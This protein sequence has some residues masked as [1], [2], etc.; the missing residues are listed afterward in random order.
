MKQFLQCSRRQ[1]E[2]VCICCCGFESRV[3]CGMSDIIQCS[4][5]GGV[6]TA[7][8]LVA[9]VTVASVEVCQAVPTHRGPVLCVLQGCSC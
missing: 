6:A 4:L 2:C 3:H 9:I 1:C 5:Y 8:T 7:H